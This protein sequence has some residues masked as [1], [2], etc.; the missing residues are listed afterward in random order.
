MFKTFQH[1]IFFLTALCFSLVSGA[2]L[3][4]DNRPGANF[5]NLADAHAAAVSGDTILINGST[6]TYPT[7]TVTKRLTLIGTGYFLN[8]N[9]GLQA[10]TEASKVNSVRLSSGSDNSVVQGLH[11]VNGI[12]LG[13][14]KLLVER[15]YITGSTSGGGVVRLEGGNQDSSVMRQNFIVSGSDMSS[16]F[17]G[18]NRFYF[19]NNYISV[20]TTQIEVTSGQIFNNIFSTNLI[21]E[22]AEFNNNIQV[23]GNFTP[24]GLTHYNNIGHSTQFGTANG[25]QSSV[26]MGTVFVASGTTDSQWQI[27]AEGPAD[28]GGFGGVDCGIFDNSLGQAYI[29]SGIPSI[30]AIYSFSADENLESVSL[31]VRSNP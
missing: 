10:N 8:E 22:N 5:Q 31:E 9:S 21:I 15:C 20:P 3:T 14:S 6:I 23:S 1:L 25:N 7:I 16:L 19:Y 26:E 24:A 13:A 2:V 12:S 17:G 27:L 4:V 18:T 30:P 11:I 28:G 29:L